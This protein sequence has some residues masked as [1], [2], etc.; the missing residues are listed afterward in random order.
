MYAARE[1]ALQRAQSVARGLFRAGLN[2]VSDGFGLGQIEFVIEEGTLAEFSRPCQTGAELDA[3]TQ[4]Q[5]QHY[6]SAVAL[7]LQ[8]VFASKRMRAGEIQR[9]TLV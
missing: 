6:R 1:L 9:Q 8:Y 5:I 7:Q 4:E 3:T 2:K